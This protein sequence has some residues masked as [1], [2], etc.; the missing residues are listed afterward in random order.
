M[1]SLIKI[2]NVRQ[3]EAHLLGESPSSN[4]IDW[5]NGT[6]SDLREL[7]EETVT[8]VQEELFTKIADPQEIAPEVVVDP[9]RKSELRVERMQLTPQQQAL[10]DKG[11]VNKSWP[12][13]NQRQ[14]TQ[15]KRSRQFNMC[16][17]Q[18]CNCS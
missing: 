9:T 2:I 4:D 18:C 15:R 10:A 11:V 6:S 8:A 12:R 3:L 7:E 14:K 17:K 13:R 5:A 16:S 1:S